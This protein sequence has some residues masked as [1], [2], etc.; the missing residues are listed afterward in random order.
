LNK[1]VLAIGIISLL[2]GA[3]IVLFSQI[4]I[5]TP[6][7]RNEPTVMNTVDRDGA[8]SLSNQ[9]TFSKTG[10]PFKVEFA[11]RENPTVPVPADGI[12]IF[13]NITDPD[14]IITKRYLVVTPNDEK[15]FWQTDI[16]D[17]NGTGIINRTGIHK[18]TIFTQ[19]VPFH[20]VRFTVKT[21]N[22]T[23]ARTD[24]PNSS[25]Y[26]PG[27]V[28]LTAGF[29]LIAIGLLVSRRRIRRAKLAR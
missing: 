1:K 17:W 5:T 27:I 22:I 21:I 9:T 7:I 29:A 10:E 11:L 2:L 19:G 4:S 6:L 24:Y 8:V 23:E 16:G 12:E 18:M 13:T 20:F 28:T 14:G 25:L 15:T 3:V 26:Y